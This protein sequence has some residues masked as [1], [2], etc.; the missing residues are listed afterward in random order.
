MSKVGRV[1]AV[2]F[3]DPQLLIV[4]GLLLEEQQKWQTGGGPS[5]LASRCARA[6]YGVI[7]REIY[8]PIKHVGQ[9][10]WLDADGSKWAVDQI[11]WLVKQGGP[12]GPDAHLYKSFSLRLKP[13]DPKRCWNVDIVISNNKPDSLPRSIR[14]GRSSL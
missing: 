7:V 5:V 11:E 13:G 10:I 6:S 2:P 9:V 14:D 4:K 1:V 12:I 3:Q 8:S